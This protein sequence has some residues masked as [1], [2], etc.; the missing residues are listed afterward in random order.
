MVKKKIAGKKTKKE[1]V[2]KK[3]EEVDGANEATVPLTKAKKPLATEFVDIAP[4]VEEKTDEDVIEG[5]E[6]GEED[7]EELTLDEEEINPFGDKWE[8]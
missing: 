4:I 8:Q 5:L 2:T 3:D 7:E 6:E 1:I